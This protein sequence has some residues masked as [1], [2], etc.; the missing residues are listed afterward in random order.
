M[1]FVLY[2]LWS[3][4]FWCA[5]ESVCPLRGLNLFEKP[6]VSKFQIPTVLQEDVLRLEVSVDKVFAMEVLETADDLCC[7]ESG[8]VRI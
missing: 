2:N 6:K 5:A 7:V 4:V 1:T 3:D 8:V